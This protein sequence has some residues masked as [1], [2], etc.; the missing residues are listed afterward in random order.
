MANIDVNVSN[1]L[2]GE[3]FEVNLPD[4]QKISDLIPVLTQKMEAGD[5]PEGSAWQLTNKTQNFGYAPDDT[6][7]GANT[8]EKDN[9]ALAV[10]A[11]P[12]S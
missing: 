3:E 6:L 4:D 5:P 7:A 11:A 1:T 8:N 12:G 2:N 9:L 10:I